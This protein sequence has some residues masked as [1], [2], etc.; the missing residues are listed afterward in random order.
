M[1]AIFG[2]LVNMSEESPQKIILLVTAA[3]ETDHPALLV[4]EFPSAR[5]V[6][7]ETGEA[8]L[9][10]VRKQTPELVIFDSQLKDMDGFQACL[11]FRRLISNHLP[12]LVLTEP[13]ESVLSKEPGPVMGADDYL[14]RNSSGDDF[15]ASVRTLW[16]TKQILDELHVRLDAQWHAYPI[17]RQLA[18][19]D[20][21]TGLYNR[22]FLSE[23]LDRESLLSIRYHTPL[24]GILLEIDNLQ[25]ISVKDGSAVADWALQSVASL[26][27][28]T[29]RQEDLIARYDKEVCAIL[30]PMISCSSGV[31]MGERL[32]KL[33]E[34][35]EWDGPS[36]SLPITISIG[37]ASFSETAM[38]TPDELWRL[39]TDALCRA[40]ASG[41]NRVEA[42]EVQL[43]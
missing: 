15:K 17:L 4:Q 11:V 26:L 21:L 20:H 41:G 31:E 30:M 13:H 27:R 19:T 43:S 34:A 16:E 24:T 3:V 12:I 2:R 36:G 23:I 33:V 22:F 10:F 35:Y 9:D 32:R 37:V 29:I 25:E 7:L 40:K 14:P 28:T 6:R 8:A 5:I 42:G 18:L 39:A 1:G 38:L